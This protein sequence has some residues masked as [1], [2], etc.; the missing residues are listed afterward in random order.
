ME[1]VMKIIPFRKTREFYPILSMFDD[2]MNQMMPDDMDKPDVRGMAMDV[3]ENDREFI[4]KANLPGIKKENV[5]VSV[6][7]NRL[8]IEAHQEE[9]KEENSGTIHRS[10]RYSGTYLR[11][12]YLPESVDS[13]NIKAKMEDGILSLTIPKKEIEPQKQITVD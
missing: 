7:E 9:K 10:E 5:K 4:I 2:F 11:S 6:H 3:M 13:N 12:L 1:V 8:T